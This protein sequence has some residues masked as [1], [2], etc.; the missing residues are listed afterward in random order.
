MN[1]AAG[2]M[3]YGKEAVSLRLFLMTG[4]LVMFTL[5]SAL[6]I[7]AWVPFM[8]EAVAVDLDNAPDFS[9]YV[10]LHESWHSIAATS[11]YA[12]CGR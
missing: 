3:E 10:A 12:S 1:G 11:R 6:A 7:I 9:E 4:L 8:P 2:G 5:M